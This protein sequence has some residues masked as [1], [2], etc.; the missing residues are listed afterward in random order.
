MEGL[1]APPPPPP[2]E[3]GGRKLF[4]AFIIDCRG[5]LR[6]PEKRAAE[7]KGSLV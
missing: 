1:L 2:F 3:K 7:K 5:E 4:A 6:S